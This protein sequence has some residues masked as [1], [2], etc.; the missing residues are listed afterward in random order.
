MESGSNDPP[1]VKAAGNRVQFIFLIAPIRLGNTHGR[2]LNQGNRG[3]RNVT[4]NR[5][6]RVDAWGRGRGYSWER[7]YFFF[8]ILRVIS[9]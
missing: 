8:P 7:C 2:E 1:T 3:Q 4:G 6:V 5:Q 9:S